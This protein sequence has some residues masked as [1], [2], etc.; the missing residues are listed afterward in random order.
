ME[1]YG[2]ISLITKTYTKD[3]LGQLVPTETTTDVMCN[4]TSVSAAEWARAGQ[5]GLK[6]SLVFDVWEYEYDGQE[7]LTY[8]GETYSVYRT[9]INNDG[10][11]ELYTEKKVGNDG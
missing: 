8:N 7:E 10:K 3:S 9:Y 1:R 6:A 4:V 11:V 2:E 5:E